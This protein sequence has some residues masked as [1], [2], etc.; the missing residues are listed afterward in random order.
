[1]CT[2]ICGDAYHFFEGSGTGFRCEQNNAVDYDGCNPTTCAINDG[3]YCN[4]LWSGT[5]YSTTGSSCFDIC[6]DGYVQ[7]GFTNANACDTDGLTDGCS[8]TC[9]VQDGFYCYGGTRTTESTCYETC[10]DSYD[11]Q[12]YL[13]CEDGNPTQYDGCY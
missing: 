2:E 8:A 12:V 1:T 7:A 11:F 6:Q 4:T 3:W 10:G 13:D 9:T 5:G